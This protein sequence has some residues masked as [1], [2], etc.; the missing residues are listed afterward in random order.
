MLLEIPSRKH[1]HI[2]DDQLTTINLNIEKVE[3]NIDS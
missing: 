3:V 1:N 2:F